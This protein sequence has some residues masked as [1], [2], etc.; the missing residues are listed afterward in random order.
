MLMG[1]ANAGRCSDF[2]ALDLSFR[3]FQDGGGERNLQFQGLNKEGCITN[4]GLLLRMSRESKAL[5]SQSTE[6]L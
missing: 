5:P 4:R 2:A 3:S 6:V 1:L